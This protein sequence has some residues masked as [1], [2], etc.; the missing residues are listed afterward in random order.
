MNQPIANPQVQHGLDA[1]RITELKN[2]FL[3]ISEEKLARTRLE[4]NERQQVVLDTLA[5]LFHYN[6]PALPGYVGSHTPS[7]LHGFS[8][9]NRNK[10][11]IKRLA[12]DFSFE[13]PSHDAQIQAL[14]VMGSVG[15]IIHGGR[16][17][18]DLW[19]CHSPQLDDN[20]RKLL[21]Q[22][23]DRI[24]RW[25][26]AFGAELHCFVMS[27]D[28][29]K[30]GNLAD[31]DNES[32]GSC[33]QFLLLD[34]FYR[35][36]IWLGGRVPMWWFV[37]PQFEGHYDHFSQSLIRTGIVDKNDVIDFGSIA[38]VPVEEFVGAGIWQLFKGIEAPYKSVLKLL[39]LEVY[40]SEF[41]RIK[42]L[43]IEFKEKVYEGETHLN[44]LDPY[45]A[46][47]QR[48]DNYLKGRKERKRLELVRRS[49][50]FLAHCPLTQKPSSLGWQWRLLQ[51]LVHGWG[52]QHRQLARLDAR[53][54]WKANQTN[55]EKQN[56]VQE[57][58]RSYRYICDFSARLGLESVV[59]QEEMSILGRKLNAA[60]D[61]RAGKIELINP[62]ISA[63]ISE[64]FLLFK[65][66]EHADTVDSWQVFG[67]PTKATSPTINFLLKQTHSLSELLCWCYL[68][69]V[70]TTESEVI[71]RDKSLQ[72]SHIL[73]FMSAL[74]ACIPLPLVKPKHTQ[75]L[76]FPTITQFLVFA[77]LS[78][79]VELSKDQ[80][81]NADS[82]DVFSYGKD[83]LNIV[84]T[85]ELVYVNS[86]NEVVCQSFTQNAVSELAK[87]YLQI[88][89][90]QPVEQSAPEVFVQS[91]HGEFNYAIC[92]RL[93]VFLKDLLEQ[94]HR[95][96][97]RGPEVGLRYV[98][99]TGGKYHVLR[100]F[101]NKPHVDTFNSL[102]Q[103]NAGLQRPQSKNSVLALDRHTL[104]TS[105]IRLV[106]ENSQNE[107]I[108]VFVMPLALHR[109][110][111][112]FVDNNK[113]MLQLQFPF[114]HLDN[115]LHSIRHFITNVL[116]KQP[117]LSDR[118]ADIA[119]T[120][121]ACDYPI[122]FHKL[123][124]NNHQWDR[125]EPMEL[126]HRAPT[127]SEF[128]VKAIVEPLGSDQLHYRLFCDQ[129]EFSGSLQQ[130]V[131][132]VRQFIL[133]QRKGDKHYPCYL[134]DVDISLCREQINHGGDLLLSH[135]LMVKND[136][137]QKL[138]ST[139][140]R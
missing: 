9:T 17:D 70:Y 66:T 40:L 114:G 139:L 18:I 97:Q 22:K 111:V 132:A 51:E 72:Q 82:K 61:R 80:R 129:F 28:A 11:A 99:Q 50:Y 121:F 128:E 102:D 20:G 125:C 2:R 45:L 100:S 55:L 44:R 24:S 13:E 57:L 69:G 74:K 56:L 10:L 134:S 63:D 33:Q 137:E 30:T 54:K 5:A 42:S 48:V 15:S 14:F 12:N 106:I 85:I 49:L 1:K 120:P 4:L 122:N 3:A 107:G 118:R 98:F 43:G 25:A 96:R 77:N 73:Q 133:S 138:N 123:V 113:S 94:L 127:F 6:H 93:K 46:L 112:F 23:G 59:T 7:G 101:P 104:P 35:S 58:N 126:S 140:V 47:Y 16:S 89:Y 110:R 67:L 81:S 34:E 78:N 31:L 36:A 32:S 88:H 116:N 64:R 75:F 84:Q 86:W 115:L 109:A 136:I 52:W 29:F 79:T 27:S 92:D 83:H 90:N 76:T 108:H 41:P 65:R 119:A 91:P 124:Q 68:N 135:Y 95:Q 21:Q 37:P 19:I 87:R 117:L 131:A 53:N 130:Q 62:D 103:L 60:F 105:P 26:E 8:I 71:V 39:L 38:S